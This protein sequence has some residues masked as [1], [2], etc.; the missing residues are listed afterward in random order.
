MRYR[1]LYHA[2]EFDFI[3][4]DSVR[5]YRESK[6]DQIRILEGKLWQKDELEGGEARGREETRVEPDASCSHTLF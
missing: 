1:S 4:K 3:V 2:K 5:E 6:Q